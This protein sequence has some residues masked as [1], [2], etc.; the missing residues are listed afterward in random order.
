MRRFNGLYCSAAPIAEAMMS[1]RI[2]AAGKALRRFGGI[3]FDRCIWSLDRSFDYWHRTDT[4]GIVSLADLECA[5]ENLSHANPYEPSPTSVF[6]HAMK[7]L[8]IDHRDFVFVDFG[9]GKGRTLMMASRYPFAEIIGVELSGRLHTVAERNIGAYRSRSQK[10][11]R[12]R[13]V[14]MDVARFE[15]PRAN[16]VIYIYNSFDGKLIADAMENIRRV[17]EQLRYKIFL[18][19]C[20]A[21]HADVIERSGVLPERDQIKLPRVTMRRPGAI[22]SLIIHSN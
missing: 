19:Y 17:A 22:S 3:V 15:L 14:C 20:E 21:K 5:G 6:K 13:S 7:R 11:F 12:I 1:N 4:G 10:C 9:S 16:L 18:I 8:E 2:S